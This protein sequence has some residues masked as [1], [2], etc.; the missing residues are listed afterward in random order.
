VTDAPS[1]LTASIIE[2]LMIETLSIYETLVS[3][4]KAVWHSIAED[5][6]V[7]VPLVSC[8][9][10]SKTVKDEDLKF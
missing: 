5:S 7:Y 10:V 9:T 1:V 2:A 4:W 3:L 8:C 6:H